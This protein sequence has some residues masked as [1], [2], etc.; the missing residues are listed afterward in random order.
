M[1]MNYNDQSHE[2]HEV[3]LLTTLAGMGFVLKA[4]R[5]RGW[6]GLGLLA[7]GGYMT[8]SGLNGR[9][10]FRMMLRE[11][12]CSDG[13]PSYPGQHAGIKQRPQDEVEEASMESFPASDAPA[14]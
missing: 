2:S 10:P 9:R 8:Y 1:E 4:V 12:G 14:Y 5:H 11:G 13:G 6:I 7:L 3:D